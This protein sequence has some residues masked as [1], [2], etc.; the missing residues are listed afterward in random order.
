MGWNLAIMFIL[1]I[2]NFSK[3]GFWKFW[4]L[5]FFRDF[6]YPKN[7]NFTKMHKIYSPKFGYKK[8]PKK[9]KNQNFQKPFF[10]KLDITNIKIIAKFQPILISQCWDHSNSLLKFDHFLQYGKSYTFSDTSRQVPSSRWRHF[11]A[12]QAF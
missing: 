10:E 6:L 12:R 4:F 3:K 7:V 9:A 11:S 2:S 1:V 5:A 8:S